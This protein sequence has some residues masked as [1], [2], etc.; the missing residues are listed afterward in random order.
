VSKFR[1][2]VILPAGTT[3]ADIVSATLSVPGMDLPRND[4]PLPPR[5]YASLVQHFATTDDTTV[6]NSDGGFGVPER[7]T[8]RQ[9][10]AFPV[11]GTGRSSPSSTVELDVTAAV[12]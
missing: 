1:R 7:P 2:D 12:R 9:W 4:N 11:G 5:E 10:L 8:L 3:S 6:T